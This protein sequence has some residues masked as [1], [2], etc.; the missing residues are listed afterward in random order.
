MSKISIKITGLDAVQDK[1]KVIQ[2]SVKEASKSKIEIGILAKDNKTIPESNNTLADIG[3]FL[4]FG[5]S[6]APARSF[7]RMPM[8][9]RKKEIV[10]FAASV[11]TL[12]ALMNKKIK[13]QLGLIANN[14][15]LVVRE[16]F[17]SKGFGNWKD[18]A[19]RTVQQ[20]GFNNPNIWTGKLRDTLNTQVIDN[21]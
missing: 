21:K 20:K 18:N 16:A 13:I 14:C 10:S 4:E 8:M 12:D 6:R 7:L 11:F 5:T 15:L 2:E 9:L 19:E 3:S 1:I 17:N